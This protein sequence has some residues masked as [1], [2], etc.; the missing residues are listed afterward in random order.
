MKRDNT[1][2]QYKK[3]GRVIQTLGLEGRVVM[4]YDMP[5]GKPLL[6]LQHW[7]VELQRGSFIPFFPEGSQ[8]LMED[9]KL[10]WQPDD[11]PSSE[12]AKALVGKDV[13]LEATVFKQLFSSNLPLEED[14]TGFKITDR[15][16]G[17]TAVVE[18]VVTLPGQ[19]LAQ[20]H[21]HSKTILLPLAEDFITG[22]DPVKK[23]IEMKLPE[24]I[25]DL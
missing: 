19:L 2:S 11:V 22:I 5:S 1:G 15:I 16:S 4:K 12:A 25:W 7:F 8:V 13:Y 17:N 3:I 9:R 20:V 6:R 10:A 23:L 14:L 18:S 24:G 21:F